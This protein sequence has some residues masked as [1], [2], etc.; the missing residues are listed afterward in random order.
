MIDRRKWL[1]ALL[2][3]ALAV[4]FALWPWLESQAEELMNLQ[5]LS[6][7]LVRSE[8]VLASKNQINSFHA[9]A[10]ISAHAFRDRLPLE[11]SAD[12]L[13]L[14]TQTRL[15]EMAS[16]RDLTVGVFDWVLD[17]AV[18]QTEVRFAK[19]RIQVNGGISNTGRFQAEIEA[20]FP[21]AVIRVVRAN[22]VVPVSGPG[23]FGMSTEFVIDFH[24]RTAS[25]K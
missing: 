3:A 13:R 11:V 20:S 23:D 14:K 17:S 15:G 4:R 18:E 22:T 1:L 24:Y 7:K 16:K 9:A 5:T 19:A 21:N 2:G 6:A 10:K 12:A 25:V 8:G